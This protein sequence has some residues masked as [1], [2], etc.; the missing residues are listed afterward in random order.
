MFGRDPLHFI[1]S[2]QK[3]T[4]VGNGLLEPG[5]LFGAQGHRD[6]LASHPAR[7]LVAR[8]ALTRLIAFDQATQGDPAGLSQALT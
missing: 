5:E 3:L 6:G 2:F 4:L 7:P 1:E 8:P